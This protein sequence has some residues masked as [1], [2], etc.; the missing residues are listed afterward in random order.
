MLECAILASAAG[1]TVPLA[2]SRMA[3]VGAV[4]DRFQSYNVEM[5]EVTGG[6]FWKPYAAGSPPLPAATATPPSGAPAGLDPALFAYRPPIDLENARLRRLA[7]ALGP[8]YVRVS[9][10]WANSVYFPESEEAPTS[11]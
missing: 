4:D 6:R 7:A 8:A 1:L 5:V 3:R 10:T 11:P 9:G 2:V